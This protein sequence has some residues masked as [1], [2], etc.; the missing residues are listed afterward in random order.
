MLNQPTQ[1][2]QRRE[3]PAQDYGAPPPAQQYGAPK[4]PPQMAVRQQRIHAMQRLIAAMR[5]G[6]YAAGNQGRVVNR[7]RP[8]PLSPQN[9]YG[10]PKNSYGPPP[11]SG[12]GSLASFMTSHNPDVKCDGWIPIPGPAHESG[13]GSAGHA[14]SVDS[15]Y[16]PPRHGSGNSGL[17]TQIIVVPDN[18]YGPPPQDSYGAP[19]Q[20]SY[21]PPS[22]H[23][24]SSGHS[25]SHNS[26]SA[27]HSVD[28]QDSYGPPA[29]VQPPHDSYGPPNHSSGP[30]G[31]AI[32]VQDSY[33]PPPQQPLDSYGPPS[34]HSEAGHSHSS[35][36][37]SSGHSH[38]SHSESSGHSINVQESYGAPAPVAQPHDSY[39]PPAQSGHGSAGH[40]ID[41][42]ES[43]GAPAPV[44]Q[45]HDSYGPPS[46]G[47]GS[48]GH[49]IS[50]QETYGPPAPVPI[51]QDSYGPPSGHS[52]HSESS[53]HSHSS[54]DSGSSFDSG[55][56]G[57]QV[58]HSVYGPPEVQPKAPVNSYGPPPSGNSHSESHGESHHHSSQGHASES[59]FS[60]GH[61]G[62]G[63]D[64]QTIHSLGQGLQLP[65]ITSGQ[66]FDNA[67]GLVTSSL[68]VS[69]GQNEVI[70]SHA[71]HESHTSEVSQPCYVVNQ[72]KFLIFIHS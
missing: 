23:S 52:G 7:P 62:G 53:G 9:S 60:Q 63:G 44:Q 18:S 1:E 65:D 40:A 61:S 26:G 71:I 66:H 32:N 25:H 31:H 10:P 55:Y 3:A 4:L 47:G 72:F 42:Q 43:Y 56:Q 49:V 69:A 68:G 41:I 36:S 30:A 64:I 51:P 5:N 28:I 46:H 29:Q 50:V 59:H 67:I 24:E 12:S 8:I 58:G 17:N 38:S 2:A 37:E 14:H 39:G 6:G 20:D 11:S 45:P 22:G 27:G 57:Q 48:A 16:G 33:G 34:G 13:G 21:G 15:S 35:H 19:P 70:P 54:V